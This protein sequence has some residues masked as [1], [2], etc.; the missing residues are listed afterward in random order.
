MLYGALSALGYGIFDE[1]HQTFV[2]TRTGTLRDVFI[3]MIGI[4]I[5]VLYTK[6]NS[7]FIKKILRA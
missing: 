3:D 1:I 4:S 7:Q 5:G 2:P 6:Y